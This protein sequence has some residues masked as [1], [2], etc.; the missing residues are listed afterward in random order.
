MNRLTLKPLTAFKILNFTLIA[1]F[2]VFMNFINLHLE[3]IVGLTGSQIGAVT[4]VSMIL[5]IVLNPVLG[6]IGDVTGQHVN[7]LRTA[8]LLTLI[9]ALI[10]SQSMTFLMVIIVAVLF[11]GTR[12]IIPAF[13][14]FLTTDYC[15]KEGYDYGK[16]RVYASYGFLLMTMLV[17]FMIAGVELNFGVIS[18]GFEGFMTIQTALFGTFFLL[19]LISLI[20]SISLP[21]KNRHEKLDAPSFSAADVL[22]LLANKR[23]VFIVSFVVLSLITFETSKMF[24]GNHLVIGLG[25]S[26]NIVSWITLIMVAP[27]LLLI[28][29][30]SRLIKKVGFKRWYLFA[31][32]TM[33][34]RTLVYSVTTSVNVFVVVS[35]VHSIGIA[36]HVSGN[37]MYIRKVVPQK[38]LGLAFTVL[39]SSVALSRAFLSFLYGFLYE[40]YDGF[41]VFR[42]VA[43]IL[44]IGL[45]MV[46]KSKS[47]NEVGNQITA[48]H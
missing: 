43:V 21:K 4:M 18:F 15:E 9:M 17:G 28:P 6:Y 39:A 40:R 44:T 26:E 11:E 34:F 38:N 7:M 46:I 48:E 13:F 42:A 31:M 35:I 22:A 8:F 14:D 5:V 29:H 41:A 37:I 45:V 36:M 24:F 33:I 10:Y 19:M 3:Q 23:Y 1:A 32:I 25:A 12:A 27:E 30:A 20:V 2:G 16:V 47:L